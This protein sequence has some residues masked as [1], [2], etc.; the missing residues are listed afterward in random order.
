MTDSQDLLMFLHRMSLRPTSSL[1]C[2]PT[3]EN[4]VRLGTPRWTHR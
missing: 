2:V 1:C 4:P 3:R